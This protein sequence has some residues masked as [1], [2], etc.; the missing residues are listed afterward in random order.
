MSATELVQ[1][2][3]AKRSG[4]G[5]KA[6]CPAHDDRV[7][8][9]SIKE[10]SDGR[11]LLHCFAGCSIDDILRAIGLARRDLFPTGSSLAPKQAT[12]TEPYPH[13]GRAPEGV[14]PPGQRQ[15]PQEAKPAPVL[16][17][18]RPLGEI[19]D[20][21]TR[22]LQRWVVFQYPEQAVICALWVL[23]TWLFKAFDYTPY[24]WVYAADMR[25]GKSRLLEVLNL[26]TPKACLTESGT[27]ASLI[28]TIDEA[29]PPTMLLDEIDVLYDNKG[30][31]DAEANNT[32]RFLNAG[33][34]RGS[35]FLRCV[36]QGANLT[37]VELPAFCPK[38]LA[39]IGRDLPATVQDRSLP[40]E[41]VRQTREERAERFRDREAR[42]ATG[43]S[44]PTR[45]AWRPAARLPTARDL[46][47]ARSRWTT[48]VW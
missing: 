45:K 17:Q 32:K 11:V 10:G 6:K 21:V 20:A 7:P 36:G 26:L 28:R 3:N 19:L 14:G 41:L 15:N 46:S 29:N 39:G 35:K 5:W 44:S 40:I 13:G 8:S 43:T 37:P 4:E 23:H 42:E 1:R 33:Y 24:L 47:R 16:G 34:K 12:A 48:A 25:S 22:F 27:S 31:G 9:L 38:A 30:K 2:L 18:P